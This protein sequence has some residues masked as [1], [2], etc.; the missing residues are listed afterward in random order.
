MTEADHVSVKEHVLSLL[1]KHESSEHR[2]VDIAHEELTHW[3][4]AHNNWQDQLK[5]AVG[6]FVGRAEYEAVVK[7]VDEVRQ[8]QLTDRIGRQEYSSKVDSIEKS[9]SDLRSRS[10]WFMGGLAVV[11]FLILVAAAAGWLNIR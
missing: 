4:Q 11:N 8:V 1:E 2:A 5:A 3:R 10:N 7:A 6:T 9:I